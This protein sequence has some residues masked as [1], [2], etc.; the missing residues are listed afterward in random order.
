VPFVVAQ[1]APGR[2]G[3]ARRRFVV[4]C[5]A[6]AGVLAAVPALAAADPAPAC[7]ARPA[8]YVAP[9]DPPASAEL[10]ADLR[11]LRQD[12]ADACALGHA[13]ALAA[14]ADAAA[15]AA[16]LADVELHPGTRVELAGVD[17]DHPLATH[18][19]DQRAQLALDPSSRDALTGAVENAG[20]VLHTDLWFLVG[21]LCSLPFSYFLVRLVLA[22]A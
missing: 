1:T 3:R 21:L 7:P 2:R 6:V 18:D 10:L 8:D 12:T 16:K 14:H 17:V 9:A 4:V 13:D 22:R 19:A 20:T 11:A 15:I 5:L